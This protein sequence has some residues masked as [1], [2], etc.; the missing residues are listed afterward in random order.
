MRLLLVEDD[1]AQ[2]A[3]L[4]PA[5]KAAGFAVDHAADG[6]GGEQ[7]GDTEPYDVVVLDLGLPRRPGLEVL[8]HWR[9]Q[10]RDLPVLVLTARD[11]WH[12][13]V[14]G[15]KAGADDYLGKPFHVEELLARLNALTRRAAPAAGR[16]LAVDGLS[17]D[18]DGQQVVLEDGRAHPLTGTEFRLLRYLLRNPERILSK[19]QLMEH[20]YDL[21]AEPSSN[22]IEVYIRRL[23]EKIGR[24]RIETLRGQGYRLKRR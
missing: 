15:L 10:G 20:V 14:D 1:L 22:L 2:V 24:D 5:L 6:I 8:R 7:L 4:L 18:E 21:D 19:T 11:A 9:A 16:T 3:A 13:R 12:E 23:R 17:L